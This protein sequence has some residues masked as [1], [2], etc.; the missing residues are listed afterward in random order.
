MKFSQVCPEINENQKKLLL[1]ELLELVG[2]SEY[3]ETLDMGLSSW[4]NDDFKAF[5][6]NELKVKLRQKLTDYIT[7]E[8][9]V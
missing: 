6:Q 4:A 2:E 9:N 3:R 8:E 5:G 1:R 7:N